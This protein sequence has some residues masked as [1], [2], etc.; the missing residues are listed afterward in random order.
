[1]STQIRNVN[2]SMAQ[3]RFWGGEN[4]GVCLQVTQKSL[5]KAQF[6]T[7]TKKDAAL[8]AAELT[9]FAQGHEV[10]DHGAGI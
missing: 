9:L 6:L 5:G 4:R 2:Q 3:T 8:L 10:V 1:M 7:L